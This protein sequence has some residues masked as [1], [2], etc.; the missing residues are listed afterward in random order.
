MDSMV[1]DWKPSPKIGCGGVESAGFTDTPV[2]G[3]AWRFLI[4]LIIGRSSQMLSR[5]NAFVCIHS[6]LTQT[7]SR[8]DQI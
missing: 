4:V 2:F 6:K 3:M 7:L 8:Y 5:L 1:N